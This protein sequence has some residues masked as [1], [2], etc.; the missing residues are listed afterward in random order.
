MALPRGGAPGRRRARRAPAAARAGS[1]RRAS[2]CSVKRMKAC[3]PRE[4]VFTAVTLM[5]SRE[6]AS[7][8]SRSSPW[9]SSA[10]T[11]TSAENGA[12]PVLP[13]SAGISRSRCSAASPVMFGQSARC[14]ITPRVRVMKPM[15]GSGGTGL[16]HLAMSVAML[17]TPST[18]TPEE[19]REAGAG[20]TVTARRRARPAPRRGP[21][22]RSA[23]PSPP[24]GRAR[25]RTPRCA[26]SRTAAAMRSCAKLVAPEARELLFQRRR[27]RSP[28][29][30][31]KSSWRNHCRTFASAARAR[32]VARPRASRATG[33]PAWPPRSRRAARCASFVVER[34]HLPVDLRAAAAMAEVGVHVVGEVDRRR[35]RGQVHHAPLRREDVDRLLEEAARARARPRPPRRARPPSTRAP[36]AA[37]RSCASNFWSARRPS[38]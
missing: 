36:A 26:G 12:S 34:H 23:S 22:S 13:Q 28:T 25:R 4:S 37:T 33:R 3:A 7:E 32:E 2:T 5:R 35:A 30:T 17:F 1:R 16:Q 8:M 11:S 20:T 29:S 14:T 38:L 10:T 27:G 21:R 31:S 15:I 18:S 6:I 24:R 19:V 9:R